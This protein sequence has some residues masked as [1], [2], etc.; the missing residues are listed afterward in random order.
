MKKILRN[1]WFFP[2]FISIVI[3]YWIFFSTAVVSGSSMYPTYKDGD[4]LLLYKT[5]KVNYGDIVAI[6]SKVLHKDLCKRVIGVAGDHLVINKDGLFLN[7]EYVNEDYINEQDWCPD[8]NNPKDIAYLNSKR[9][10]ASSA[11]NKPVIDI[12]IKPNEVFVMGDNRNYSTDSRTIGCLRTSDILGVAKVNFTR[13]LGLK[14]QHLSKICIL[15]WI[16]FILS[17]IS[18]NLARRNQQS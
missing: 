3:I 12:K 6:D 1:Y 8:T 5:S 10:D 2:V 13:V 17:V 16:L 9:Y 15:L 4:F 14:R 7:G 18:N 11:E